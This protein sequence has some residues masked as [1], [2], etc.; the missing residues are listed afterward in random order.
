MK[1]AL[2]VG[3]EEIAA[4]GFVHTYTYYMYMYVQSGRRPTSTP[5]H[6]LGRSLH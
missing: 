6:E 5:L 4:V 1:Y 2:L 3:I